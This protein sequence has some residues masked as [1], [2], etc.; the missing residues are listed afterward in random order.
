MKIMLAAASACIAVALLA[1]PASAQGVVR[2]AEKG[3]AVGN[4]TAGPVG[5]VVGGTIGGVAGGIA[6]GVKGVL[7]IP[8][9]TSTKSRR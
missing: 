8:Q 5:A 3:A 4:R 9:N 7:G 1:P 6:G 2:G